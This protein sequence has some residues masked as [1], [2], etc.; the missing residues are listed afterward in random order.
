[1][2]SD[3]GDRGPPDYRR[4]RQ[5]FLRPRSIDISLI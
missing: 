4:E 1:M 3:V 5:E 2:I